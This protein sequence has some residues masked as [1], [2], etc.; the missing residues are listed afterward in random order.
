MEKI[1]SGDGVRVGEGIWRVGVPG[2]GVEGSDGRDIQKYTSR[3]DRNGVLNQLSMC[4]TMETWMDCVVP[5]LIGWGDTAIRNFRA[6]GE[7]AANFCR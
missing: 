1:C 5:V 6:N 4:L 7:L 2:N 3:E